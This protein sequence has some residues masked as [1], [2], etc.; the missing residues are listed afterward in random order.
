MW[1]WWV[2]VLGGQSSNRSDAIG[3]AVVGLCVLAIFGLLFSIVLSATAHAAEDPYPLPDRERDGDQHYCLVWSQHA[4][5]AAA[6]YVY[7]PPQVRELGL[8][9]VRQTSAEDR[10]HPEAP[11][12]LV[13][14]GEE[15]AV[16]FIV[17]DGVFKNGTPWEASPE[18]QEWVAGASR[19]G[20]AWM[21][22]KVK[23][24]GADVSRMRVMPHDIVRRFLLMDCLNQP[25]NVDPT[26]EPPPQSGFK[27]VASSERLRTDREQHCIWRGQ[28]SDQIMRLVRRDVSR[29]EILGAPKEPGISDAQ[30]AW[31]AKTEAEA[32]AWRGSWREFV[33]CIYA[34]CM[35]RTEG[36][37]CASIAP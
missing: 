6:V 4:V 12:T 14:A 21:E 29:E 37:K 31:V 3:A 8:V 30:V 26:Y 27:K 20:W 32:R 13:L 34:V 28:A 17:T 15:R 10:E 19:A 25:A 11:P 2:R 1:N 35:D 18:L 23:L 7:S 5:N 36:G 9:I 22:R 16:V 24:E 33:D